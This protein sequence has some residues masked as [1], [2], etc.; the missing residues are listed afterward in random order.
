MER[1]TRSF[2]LV[3]Q[4][5]RILMRDKEL[6]ILPLI[7][8]LVM[9]V[10]VASFFL[11]FGLI[12]AG[13]ERRAPEF[14]IPMLLMYIVTYAIGIFFQAA[15]IAGATERMRGG[16]P[17]V[18]SALAAARRR[19]GPIVMWAVLAGT[20]GMVLR[21]I[22]DRVGF[23]GKIVAGL[24]GVAWSL[25]TFFI[26]PVLVLEDKSIKDSFLQSVSVFKK[27]WGETVSGGVGLGIA[28]FVAWV[29]LFALVALFATVAGPLALV[30]FIAGAI[31]LAIFFSTLQG[32][33]L[34]SLYR[35][36]TEGAV[37]PDFDRT[38]LDNAFMPKKS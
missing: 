26:V 28:A 36:A 24:A 34:A 35:F 13:V 16:D 2:Q 3:G 9:A 10:A 31:L 7:S 25:A 8:G 1:I 12:G 23:V 5:Y 11:A 6:M 27:T 19:L 17:T 22:Q 18:G 29:A 33:Y 30:V 20:V 4:S 21:A 37:P 32:I 38:L 14:Y 15:V